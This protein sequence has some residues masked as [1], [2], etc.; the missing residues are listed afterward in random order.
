[1][2][3]QEMYNNEETMSNKLFE[4][5]KK[6]SGSAW[7]QHGFTDVVKK[8]SKE[9]VEIQKSTFRSR[10]HIYTATG[11]GQPFLFWNSG[12]LDIGGILDYNHYT[13]LGTFK[14]KTKD[15][16]L[17]IKRVHSYHVFGYLYPKKLLPFVSIQLPEKETLKD[18]FVSAIVK[19]GDKYNFEIYHNTERIY[20]YDDVFPEEYVP[21][22]DKGLYKHRKPYVR[23]SVSGKENI[24][25]NLMYSFQNN[26]MYE[27]DESNRFPSFYTNYEKTKSDWSRFEDRVYYK[28][29]INIFMHLNNSKTA[30][31]VAEFI[32]NAD[33]CKKVENVFADDTSTNLCVTYINNP[34]SVRFIY[35]CAS[36]ETDLLGFSI[37]GISISDLEK[38]TLNYE[39]EDRYMLDENINISYYKLLNRELYEKCKERKR[40]NLLPARIYDNCINHS[41]MVVY[42]YHYLRDNFNGKYNVPYINGVAIYNDE[43]DD[44]K[45]LY[46]EIFQ[47][48]AN[49]GGYKTKWK[50]ELSLFQTVKKEY[51]D[52]IYQYHCEWLGRQSLDVFVPSINTGFEYQGRQHYEAVDFFGGEKALK[53]RIEL[54]MRKKE[55]CKE[56]G[57]FLIEWRYDEP[58]SLTLLRKKLK[59]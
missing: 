22:T 2:K 9:I 11:L 59:S 57:V 47:K 23:F 13:Q 15:G 37:M 7:E 56:N 38:G 25:K 29:G 52:A 1:M 12:L 50:N 27:L 8:N 31:V 20:K 42:L 58:I 30:Q 5:T 41:E 51:S 44:E 55:L 26:T 10:G 3:Y 19:C 32:K 18:I 54:D 43:F 45:A 21:F 53:E 16:V 14:Q 17:E 46:K 49:E 34:K 36:L 40:I 33:L 4:Y 28:N 39:Y 6:F 48:I 24:F 35:Y